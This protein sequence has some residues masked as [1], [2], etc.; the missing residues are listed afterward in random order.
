MGTGTSIAAIRLQSAGEDLVLHI[1]DQVRRDIDVLFIC[2]EWGS[3]RGGLSTFNREF[4]VHLAKASSEHLK[5]HCYVCSS[6]EEDRQDAS[7]QGVN[8]ITATR[9]PGSVDPMEGLKI[10]PLDL[11]YPHVVVGHGRKFGSAARFISERAKCSW[12]QFVHVFCEALGKYKLEDSTTSDAI[13]A[14]QVKHG[15]ELELCKA[16]DLVVAVG[17][18]LQRKYDKMLPDIKVE[19]ITPGIFEKFVIQESDECQPKEADEFSVFVFGRGSLEDF[20][21]KGY[22][23]IAN[24]VALLERNFELTFV[25]SPQD[26]QRK[27]EKWFLKKTLIT[28]EQLTIRRYCDCE[29]MKKMFRE[30]DVVV[31][32]SRTEGFGLVALEA[33]SFGVPV[34]VSRE[35]G[36]AKALERMEDGT[37]VVVNSNKPLDWARKIYRLSKLDPK[38]RHSRAINLREAY[39]YVYDWQ[40]ECQRFEEMI[41]ELVQSPH[42]A[43]PLTLSLAGVY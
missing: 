16:A 22:D 25:G 32:P 10:L 13:A 12:V 40:E 8:L 15:Q 14:Y 38:E 28:Q 41:Y 4:A 33:I 3:S 6:S 1:A 37:T 18:Q 30:A 31:M 5:I 20:K 34:L 35:C 43:V 26:E 23:I 19:S 39:E 24:A 7:E 11:P 36:I 42:R 17:S 27:I 21:L 29:E 9:L 2:D